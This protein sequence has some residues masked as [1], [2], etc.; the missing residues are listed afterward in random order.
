M[1]E[2]P[3]WVWVDPK[4]S[5]SVAEMHGYSVPCDTPRLDGRADEVWAAL[6]LKRINPET[7]AGALWHLQSTGP[8]EVRSV[9]PVL[10]HREALGG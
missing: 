1:H 9:P 8:W 2:R 6:W 4:D 5:E 10:S 7:N 3:L